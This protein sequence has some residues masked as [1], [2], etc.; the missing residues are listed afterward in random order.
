[1]LNAYKYCNSCSIIKDTFKFVITQNG[2]K[3][4]KDTDFQITMSS[5]FNPPNET[6]CSLFRHHLLSYY[7]L[8]IFKADLVVTHYSSAPV[9][10]MSPCQKYRVLRADII[11]VFPN[12]IYAG[13]VH[14]YTIKL[15]QPTKMLRVMLNCS[16]P[17]VSFLPNILY[18]PNYDITE[19]TGRII[20]SSIANNNKAY[21]NIT[22]EESGTFNFF[23]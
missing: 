13:M 18:F 23:R 1:M 4:P 2:I 6:D 17:F 20:V 9:N 11:P 5:L 15:S 8:M 3:I 10:M 22:H 14:Q 19:F 16:D 12:V 7:K 21:F